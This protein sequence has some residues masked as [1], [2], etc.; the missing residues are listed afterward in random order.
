MVP[1]AAGEALGKA[2]SPI[3]G[4]VEV[5]ADTADQAA[6]PALLTVCLFSFFR[7]FPFSFFLSFI[8]SLGLHLTNQLMSIV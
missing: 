7:F 5:P 4:R 6:E 3:M 1:A 8:S 2:S